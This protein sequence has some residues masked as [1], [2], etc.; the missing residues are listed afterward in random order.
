MERKF[1]VPCGPLALAIL[2]AL[3]FLSAGD[4]QTGRAA[5]S[6]ALAIPGIGAWRIGTHDLDLP[7]TTQQLGRYSVVVLSPWQS[8]WVPLIKADSP[9]TKVLMYT[10]AVDVSRDCD[11]ASEELSCQTG[12]TLYDVNA[13]D[14]SWLLR[15][16]SG[17]PIVNA[18][19]SYYY[20]GDIGSS[21]YRSKWISHV[22]N[23]A[24][25][26]GFDGVSIDGVLG[27]FSGETGGVVPA[28]YPSEA[29]WRSAMAG[30]VAAVGPALKAQGLYVGAEV[31]AWDDAGGADNNDGSYDVGWWQQ[32]AP[33]LSAL[34]CEYF[35][36][37]PNNWSQMYSNTHQNWTDN[38]DGWLKLVD[39]AQNAGADFWGLNYASGTS[40]DVRNM[41]Y[42]KASFLLKWDGG[43]GGAYFWDYRDGTAHDVWDPNWTMDI[44]TPSGAMYP[45]GSGAFRRDYSDGTVI[46][47]PMQTTQSFN[48]GA[49]Y[50]TPTG[51]SVTSVTL[52]P[53]SAAILHKVDSG[54]TPTNTSVPVISGMAQVGSQLSTSAGT[55]S[56][57]PT[58]Y[59]DEWRR[60]DSSGGNCTAISGA[61]GTDYPLT[62]AD[63]GATIRVAVTAS[64]SSGA[65]TSVSTQTSVVAPQSVAPSN[66]GLPVVSGTDQV[67]SQ[68]SAS[69]GSWSGS[70]TSYAYQWDRCDSSGANCAAISGATNTS[71][72]L[73]SADGGATI[74]VAVTASNSAGS[75]TAASAQTPMVAAPP[76]APV[77]TGVPVI[78]GTAQ[79]GQTLTASR[80]AW[81]G[82]PTGYAYQWLRCDATG[83]NCSAVSGALGS[84]YS[85]ARPDLGST[86]RVV[87]LASNSGGSA[88]ATS[89][90]TG[91]VVKPGKAK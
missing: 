64:N 27:Q 68:L 56:G 73:V 61:T 76:S 60:C 29:A 90:P 48:L 57:S 44:G 47:N 6:P 14:S 22:T 51:A 3:V 7:E 59:T 63:Q 79:Q 86:L 69:A 62:S 83:A 91:V 54:S 1:L 74:R 66:S 36:Q 31:Y 81:S 17:N 55:W 46:V 19:Y 72:L 89:L 32:V 77:N 8:S 12:V 50:T 78:S 9:G 21:T 16:A 25:T 2:V 34:F 85:L 35:E 10:N 20:V 15:D 67:G 38:W 24:K 23:Q 75:S 45:V 82:N 71:Y 4:R 30:F 84:N 26:L 11:L 43:P 42:G 49:T 37:N 52:G 5:T 33:N 28:K 18:H 70:P 53:T 41:T 40:V 80:G 39:A 58:S 87:V 65:T 13:N 88:S